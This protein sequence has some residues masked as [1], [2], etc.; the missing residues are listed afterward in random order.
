[1]KRE[2]N[3]KKTLLRVI[4]LLMALILVLGILISAIPVK[5]VN[6]TEIERSFDILKGV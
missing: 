5:A 4:C 3:K 2:T 6:V 1:M